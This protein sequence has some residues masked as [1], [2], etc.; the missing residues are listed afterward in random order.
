MRKDRKVYILKN[1]ENELNEPYFI[2]FRR[3]EFQK[4]IKKSKLL[5]ASQDILLNKAYFY[6]DTTTCEFYCNDSDMFIEMIKNLPQQG[7][8]SCWR[9]L[10]ARMRIVASQDESI[11]LPYSLKNFY[12][13]FEGHIPQWNK[14]KGLSIMVF[15]I[16]TRE[17]EFTIV[18]SKKELKKVLVK[19]NEVRKE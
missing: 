7:V 12:W 9:N 19:V 11:Y 3:R 6:K 16:V 15:F 5:K 1:K 14:T 4:L 13:T 17:F 10:N 18:L 2:R 8:T